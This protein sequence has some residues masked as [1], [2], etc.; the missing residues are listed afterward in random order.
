MSWS[1][2]EAISYYKKQGA[3]A[4]QSM[5]ISL[6]RE[7]QQET[8]GSIPVYALDEIANA[9][10]VKDSF[11]KAIVKRIPSLRVSD[12][13]CLELCAGQNCGKHTGLAAFADSLQKT[14]PGKITVKYVPCMRM[15]GKGPNIKWDGKLYN[16]ANEALLRTIK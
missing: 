13:H 7:I 2:S 15:C 11:L 10:G 5:V 3:P 9:Y 12:T 4:D 16:Q 8:G 6:L 1:L 14:A